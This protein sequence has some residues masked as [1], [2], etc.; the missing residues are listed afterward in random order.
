M[1]DAA[2]IRRFTVAGLAADG[3]VGVTA[4]LAPGQQQC[5]EGIIDIIFPDVLRRGTTIALDFLFFL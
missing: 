3:A 4:Q 2:V 5:S 1:Y